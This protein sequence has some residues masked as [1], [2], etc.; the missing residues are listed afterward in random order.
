MKCILQKCDSNSLTN[1]RSASKRPRGLSQMLLAIGGVGDFSFSFTEIVCKT[2]AN[3]SAL[4]V[5]QM[6]EKVTGNS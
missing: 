1:A 6:G 4:N 3:L 2:N 5:Q